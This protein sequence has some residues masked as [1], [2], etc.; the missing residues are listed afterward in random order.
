[1]KTTLKT[2][3]IGLL[4]TTG[5]MF[6]VIAPGLYVLQGAMGKTPMDVLEPTPLSTPYVEL[7]PTPTPVEDHEDLSWGRPGGCPCCSGK[8]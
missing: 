1:M 6:G 3:A 2:L 5:L 7:T 4:A 8:H